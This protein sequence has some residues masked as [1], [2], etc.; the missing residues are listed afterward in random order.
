MRVGAFDADLMDSFYAE[1]RRCRAHCDRRPFVV[2]RTTRQHVCADR[3]APHECR[4]LGPSTIRQIHFI[5]SGAFKRAVRWRWV[6]TNPMP[7]AEPPPAPKPNPRP[8]SAQE[9]AAILNEAWLEPDWGTLVWLAMTTGARRGELCALR[10]SDVDLTGGVV[11]IA[12]SVAQDSAR[13]WEKA[14]KTHQHRRIALDEDTVALLS[15]HQTRCRDRAE[16][17]GLPMARD[18]Y[19]FSLEPGNGSHL[20]PDS[21]SQRYSKL[22]KRLGIDTHLHNLRH[23]SAT[24]LISAGVDVRTVAGRLGHGGGGTTTLRVYSAWVSESDQRASRSLFSRLPSRPTSAELAE[25]RAS[26]RTAPYQ[27]I[28]DAYRDQISSGLLKPGDQLPRIK[29]IAEEHGVAFGTAQRAVA[30]LCAA[31]VVVCKPG[32]RATVLDHEQPHRERT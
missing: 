22:A 26:R 32:R 24:E 31:G 20:V 11:E 13:R 25:H 4:P 27:R 5:L 28:A 16:A 12:R 15:E 1:L 9:A 30:Q 10:W 21:V 19:V 7:Q 6:A 29:A 17:V 18:A 8:P 23:Y 2:H 3:C 14:T